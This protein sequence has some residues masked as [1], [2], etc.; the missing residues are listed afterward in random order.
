MRFQA[1]FLPLIFRLLLRQSKILYRFVQNRVSTAK[2]GKLQ[3]IQFINWKS[4]FNAIRNFQKNISITVRN[5]NERPDRYS[6]KLNFTVY[7]S[8]DFFSTLRLAHVK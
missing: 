8:P 4:S 6:C 1:T 5:S 7:E 3:R 2:G